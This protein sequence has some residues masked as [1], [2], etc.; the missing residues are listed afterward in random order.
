VLFVGG[1]FGPWL[2]RWQVVIKN[3]GEGERLS[4]G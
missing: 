2:G 3:L 1:D 4:S